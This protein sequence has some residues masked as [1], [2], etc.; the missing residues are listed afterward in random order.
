MFI[1]TTEENKLPTD[2]F[3]DGELIS[4]ASYVNFKVDDNIFFVED[5]ADLSNVNYMPIESTTFLKCKLDDYCRNYLNKTDWFIT[6][7]IETE[8]A[9]P[10]NIKILRSKMR[11]FIS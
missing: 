6:K 11:S 2:I 8:T 10:E 5:G 7:S 4:I 1:K 3:E 9:I